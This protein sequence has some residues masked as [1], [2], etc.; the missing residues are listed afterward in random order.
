M[1]HDTVT[2][3]R[4]EVV[5]VDAERNVLLVKGS[6]PGPKNSLIKVKETVKK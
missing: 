1:G 4:L 5:K 3:Q 6:I 2:I